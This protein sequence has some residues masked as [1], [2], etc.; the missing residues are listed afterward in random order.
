MP[1]GKSGFRIVPVSKIT[2]HSGGLIVDALNA[3]KSLPVNKGVIVNAPSTQSNKVKAWQNAKK[4]G[5]VVTV[6]PTSAR[7]MGIY[8]RT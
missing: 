1:R 8:H 3:L 6:T 5:M 2:G 4:M 7:T